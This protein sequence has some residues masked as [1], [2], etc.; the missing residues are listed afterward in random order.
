MVPTPM[1]TPI[2][3]STLRNLCT[4]RLDAEMATASDKFIVVGRGM[5]LG[6]VVTS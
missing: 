1:T 6:A 3:V 2:S 4:H 5:P